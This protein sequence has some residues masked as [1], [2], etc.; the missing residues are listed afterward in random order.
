[1]MK[2]QLLGIPS[3]QVHTGESESGFGGCRRSWQT[4]LYFSSE[5]ETVDDK[6]HL[7]R[8]ISDLSHSFWQAL[9]TAVLLERPDDPSFFMLRHFDFFGQLVMVTFRK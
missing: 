7:D 5:R 4:W 6:F 3:L 9:V 2:R 8:E 1:M